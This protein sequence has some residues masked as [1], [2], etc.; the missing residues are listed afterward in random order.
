[1]GANVNPYEIE[2]LIRNLRPSAQGYGQ[3]PYYGYYGHAPRYAPSV[4]GSEL[5]G[6]D[7][8]SQCDDARSE[9]TT[10][11]TARSDAYT[12]RSATPPSIF[13]RRDDDQSSVGG[14]TEPP[15]GDEQLLFAHQVQLPNPIPPHPGQVLWCEFSDLIECK[16]VF[17]LDDVHSWIQHHVLHLGD[18]FPPQLM[19][20]FCDSGHA[21]FVAQ[22]PS[23][24]YANFVDRMHHIR[25]HI[26]NN[27]RLTSDDTRPDFHLITHLYHIEMIDADTFRHA[28]SFTELPDRFRLPNSDSDSHSHSSRQHGYP[29]AAPREKGQCHDLAKEKRLERRRQKEKQTGR[30][31]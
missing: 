14:S 9:F 6:S 12:I 2:H 29:Y 16:A 1:M 13:S 30:K 4:T 10:A 26:F 7:D 3:S 28:M 27:P 19:C 17:A 23:D 15:L 11:S 24:C 31:R 18:R 20:W 22:H 25:D 5:L 21:P 8:S